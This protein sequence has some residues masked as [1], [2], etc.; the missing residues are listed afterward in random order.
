MEEKTKA[1]VN[2]EEERENAHY[3]TVKKESYANFEEIPS[4]E[5]NF[6]E[7]W[8]KLV[9]E[10]LDL[11][12]TLEESLKEK[13]PSTEQDF[14]ELEKQLQENYFNSALSFE[15]NL[16]PS[17][18]EPETFLKKIKIEKGR[19]SKDIFLISKAKYNFMKLGFK[20]E[21]YLGAGKKN[22]K[23]IIISLF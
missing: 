18:L 10:S 9:S 11:G 19:S 15:K 4:N 21:S 3:E 16:L 5:R 20:F 23:N 13:E 14:K 2:V 12:L 17:S 8:K 1:Y 7:E 22:K 6:K